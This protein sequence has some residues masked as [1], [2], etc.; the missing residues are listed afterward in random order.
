M[1]GHNNFEPILAHDHIR[2]NKSVPADLGCSGFSSHPQKLATEIQYY[3]SLQCLVLARTLLSQSPASSL[4]DCFQNKPE[5][6]LH[7]S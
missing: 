7:L 5:Q 6:L 2:K 1:H 3:N 4:L